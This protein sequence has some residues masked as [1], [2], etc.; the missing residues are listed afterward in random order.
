[1]TPPCGKL[2]GG[3]VGFSVDRDSHDSSPGD[4]PGRGV[5]LSVRWQR[6]QCPNPPPPSPPVWCLVSWLGAATAVRA[7]H[8]MHHPHASSRDTGRRL[9]IGES[10][11]TVEWITCRGIQAAGF[12]FVMDSLKSSTLGNAACIAPMKSDP[13]PGSCKSGPRSK[14]NKIGTVNEIT[15]GDGMKPLRE[16]SVAL[17][18]WLLTGALFS[19]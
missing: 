10:A 9:F 12:E 17:R 1:M 15:P 18:D 13:L 16:Q 11:M 4:L 6:A 14:D 7:G 19:I 3:V 5:F 8:S 2:R